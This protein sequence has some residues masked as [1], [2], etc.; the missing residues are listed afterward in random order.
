MRG[1]TTRGRK[2]ATAAHI[3]S[4]SA[5]SSGTGTRVSHVLVRDEAVGT[6]QDRKF[7][8]VLKPDSTVDYRAVRLGRLVD[9]LRA[10]TAGLAP[11]ERVVVNGLQ[12]VRPGARVRAA[13]EP[14][15]PKASPN[16]TQNPGAAQLA[17]D[18]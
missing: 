3:T 15:A 5:A 2:S 17:A 11:G 13:E 8:L 10:V 9:G 4:R 7:V 12:R 1:A 6:D 14:M 16:G 18:R